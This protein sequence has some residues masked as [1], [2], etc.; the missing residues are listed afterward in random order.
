MITTLNKETDRSKWN[1]AQKEI[2]E[3]RGNGNQEKND[4]AIKRKKNCLFYSLHIYNQFTK[5]DILFWVPQ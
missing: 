5:F 2:V 4:L 1:V 3:K